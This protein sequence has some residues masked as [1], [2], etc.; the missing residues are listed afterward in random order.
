MVLVYFMYIMFE[1]SFGVFEKPSKNPVFAT[2]GNKLSP[3][4]K[5]KRGL[6]QIG[7][8]GASGENYER[9]MKK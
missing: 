9:G 7:E 1:I 8:S 2:I 3:K 6:R 4:M 5:K